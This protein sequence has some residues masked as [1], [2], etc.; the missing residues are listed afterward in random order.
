MADLTAASNAVA[1][2]LATVPGLRVNSGFTSQVNPPMAIVMPQPSQALRFDTFDGGITFF[3]R[4]VVLVSMTED[5]SS[6]ALL[7]AFMAT[8]G[9]SSIEAALKANPRLNGAVDY[10]VMD[11]IRGYGMMEW[12]GQQYLGF[13]ALMSVFAS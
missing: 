6:V 10:C 7:N 1:A 3:L 11:S 13:Q 5:T 4:T 9:S 12:A 8:T 2:V